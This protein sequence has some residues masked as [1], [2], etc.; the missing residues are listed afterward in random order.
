MPSWLY[1][2]ARLSY[3]SVVL[4][5]L[6]TTLLGGA[7]AAAAFLT[8]FTVPEQTRPHLA[9]M[10]AAARGALLDVETHPEW[11]QFVILAAVR[12][13]DELDR[14]R[15]LPG[16]NS[17][18]PPVTFATLPATR[19]DAAPDD[20]NATVTD[21]P[22]NVLP[23]DIG[24]TSSTELPV[25]TTMMMPPVQQPQSL[26]PA[27]RTELKPVRRHRHA[28]TRRLPPAETVGNPLS[29]LFESNQK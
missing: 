21:A 13:A 28:R 16:Q 23:I 25:G 10:P 8:G 2:A 26:Q 1:R 12:R 24:E 14:L 18:P 15:Q 29:A 11:K 5:F 19:A 9:Q 4:P 7:L 22:E 20:A 6:R 17:G 3:A 27:N